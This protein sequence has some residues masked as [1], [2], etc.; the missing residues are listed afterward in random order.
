MSDYQIGDVA[1]LTGTNISTLRLW[2]QHGLLTPKRSPTGRRLYS[3]KDLERVAHISR[4]RNIDGLNMSSI[5]RVLDDTDAQFQSRATSGDSDITLGQRFRIAR[6]HIG[7][8][9]KQVA[10]VTGLPVSYISTFE[11]TGKGATV[12]N[13]KKL[14]TC[15]GTSLTVLSGMAPRSTSVVAELVRNG[16]AIAVPSFGSGIKILQLANEL[17]SLDCQKWVLSPGARSDGAYAHYGEEF[18]HV[19]A[20]QFSIKVDLAEPVILRAGDSISFLSERPHSWYVH[21]DE[22]VVLLWV[23][24]PKSF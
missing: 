14:A 19:L 20:G 24:T 2:E 16:E 8:S 7:M 17:P 12:A 5:R 10:H 21:G 4:L 6:Q 15:Y 23:N 9:L 22:Q 1:R 18:I 11:R 3:Q 13:L